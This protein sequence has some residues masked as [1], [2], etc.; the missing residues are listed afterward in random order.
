MPNNSWQLTLQDHNLRQFISTISIVES[1]T[2][3]PATFYPDLAE[4][5]NGGVPSVVTIN[6]YYYQ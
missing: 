1:D 5:N 6:F 2:I 4:V 3:L